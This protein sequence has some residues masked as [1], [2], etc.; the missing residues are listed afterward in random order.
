M[1][2]RILI[3]TGFFY[4]ATSV[5]ANSSSQ[6]SSNTDTAVVRS[7]VFDPELATQKYLDTLNPEEKKKSDAYFEG[8]YWLMLWNIIYEIVVAWVFLSLGLS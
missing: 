3:I 1:I 7:A 2:L 4:I 5:Q 8:G 6:V